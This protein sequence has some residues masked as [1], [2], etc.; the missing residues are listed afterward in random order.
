MIRMLI[1]TY[2]VLLI[3][4]AVI[5]YIPAWKEMKWRQMLKLCADWG[6]RPIRQHLKP[7]AVNETIHIDLSPIAFFAIT[8]IIFFLW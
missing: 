7:W 6:L 1:N 8:R 4:D 3:V 2:C 5:A